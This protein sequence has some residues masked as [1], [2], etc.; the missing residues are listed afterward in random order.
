LQLPLKPG[1][2]FLVFGALAEAAGAIVGDGLDIVGGDIPGTDITKILV[3]AVEGTNGHADFPCRIKVGLPAS[4]P[5][6]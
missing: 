4:A 5:T 3:L 1:G 2:K 6:H